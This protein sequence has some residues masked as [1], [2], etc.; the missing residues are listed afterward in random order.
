MPGSLTVIKT[1]VEQ[2]LHETNGVQNIIEV[3]K[4]MMTSEVLKIIQFMLHHG[5]YTNLEEL[6]LVALP[7][8]NLLNGSNDSYSS[9]EEQQKEKQMEDVLSCSRYFSNGNNDIIVECKTLICQ[10]LLII[11][12]LEI[13]GKV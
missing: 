8:I 12:Q 9:A 10:N 4:N 13:D 3:G 7:M 2:Y 6:K 1:F 11:S 5:F